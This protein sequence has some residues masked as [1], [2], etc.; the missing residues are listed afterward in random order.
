MRARQKLREL[1]ENGDLK[2]ARN[3]TTKTLLW[4]VAEGVLENTGWLKYLVA[5]LAV[6]I[7][8]IATLLIIILC[9]VSGG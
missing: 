6:A 7:P 1:E 5:T 4:L 2:E 8:V 3:G 9:K